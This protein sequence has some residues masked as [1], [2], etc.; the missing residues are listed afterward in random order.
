MLLSKEDM[1][2][3]DQAITVDADSTNIIDLQADRDIG[4]GEPVGILIQVTETFLTTVSLIVTL[5]TDD[6]A[7]FTSGTT[8]YTSETILVADL[9]K[10]KRVWLLFMGANNERFLKLHYD[11]STTATAGKITAC[12]LR[13][14]DRQNWNANADNVSQ[15]V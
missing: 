7:A 8:I 12:L 2:S 6:N 15:L 14:G 1:F 13:K 4:L 10:G 11:I 5:I 3:D 9:V